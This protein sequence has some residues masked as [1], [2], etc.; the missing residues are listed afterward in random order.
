MDSI[1]VDATDSA[2]TL[3][4]GAFV[5]IVCS[6]QTVDDVASASGTIGYEILVRLGRRFRREYRSLAMLDERPGKSGE[7]ELSLNQKVE[8]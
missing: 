8:T 5:D 2:G 4:E 6:E 7:H 1:V 3:R